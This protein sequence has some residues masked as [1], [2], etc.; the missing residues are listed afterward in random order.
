MRYESDCVLIID[1]FALHYLYLFE[2]N[3][4]SLHSEAEI[5]NFFQNNNVKHLVLVFERK[6]S[7]VG[8]EVRSVYTKMI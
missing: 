4:F 3:T 5:D 7:Y 1:R 2:Y 6:N 8:R